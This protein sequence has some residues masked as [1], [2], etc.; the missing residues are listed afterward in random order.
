MTQT[1]SQF[2]F[3]Y[4]MPPVGGTYPRPPFL[5]HRGE[6]L[7]VPFDTEADAA[8]ALLPPGLELREPARGIVRMVRHEHSPFGVYSGAYLGLRVTWQEE[9]L[10]YILMGIVDSYVS[11]LVGREVWGIPKK[12]GTVNLGWSGEILHGY[13]ERPEG[14]RVLEVT[15]QLRDQLQTPPGQERGPGGV[16]LRNIPSP[17]RDGRPVVHLIKNEDPDS[18]EYPDGPGPLVWMANAHLTLSGSAQDP[19][20][21]LPILSVRP[22]RYLKGGTTLLNYGKIL[23]DYS[24]EL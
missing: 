17:E 12:L 7:I 6:E 13:A 23:H 22:A 2:K 11:V 15:A 20:D 8:R 5:Y 24:N 16:F 4:S 3:T 14:V 19:W 10:I 21:V 1:T 9:I 18:C